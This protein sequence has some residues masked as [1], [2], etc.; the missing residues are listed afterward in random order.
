MLNTR[1]NSRSSGAAMLAT[2]ATIL[3]LTG[4]VCVAAMHFLFAGRQ[5][6]SQQLDREI[7]FRAADVALHDAETDL[8]A[9]TVAHGGRFATWPAPGECGV[10]A[11]R[12][13]CRSNASAPVWQPWL[14][15]AH[16][17]AV[18]AIVAGTFTG[19]RMPV[20]TGAVAGASTP[21]RY[22]IEI[23]DTQITAIPDA[24]A[25]PRFR[26][27]TLGVGRDSDVRTLLQTEF[28]P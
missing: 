19:A 18:P 15:G 3:L 20:F 12:G 24:A 27:T 16:L 21:P 10:G 4:S 28:Q 7:A 14:E 23:I 6:A 2:V 5:L 1:S 13:I 26:I 9:A 8:I 22:V 17:D 11:Q 25:W